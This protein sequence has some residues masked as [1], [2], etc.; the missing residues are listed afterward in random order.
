[1][2]LIGAIGKLILR[3]YLEDNNIKFEFEYQA[4]KYDEMDFSINNEIVE[5]KTSRYDN[6]G[7]QRLNL[8]YSEDQFQAELKKNFIYCV[9][10]F[11]NGYNRRTKMLDNIFV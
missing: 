8:L 1:M 9:Q 11:I 5:V 3:K 2:I 4:G 6:T 7:F 10:I